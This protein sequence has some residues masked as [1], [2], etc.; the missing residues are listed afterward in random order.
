MTRSVRTRRATGQT[1][2]G[3]EENVADLIASGMTNR[4]AGACLSMSRH[5]VDAPLRHILR[6]LDIPS[7]VELARLVA[8]RPDIGDHDSRA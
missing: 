7:R 6:K 8:A 4:E 3:T 1:P 2:T 5:T